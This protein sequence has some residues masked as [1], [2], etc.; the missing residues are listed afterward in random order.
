[1]RYEK[2]FVIDLASHARYV[3]GKPLLCAGGGAAT[4]S[5]TCGVGITA[6]GACSTG[7]AGGLG[8]ACLG[9]TAPG[10]TEDCITGTTARY[11]ASGAA[12]DLDPLGCRSGFVVNCQTGGA[13]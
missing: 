9:G 12:G 6:G 5:E 4:G 7:D 8:T 13:A 10:A 1:M 11:C 3:S 2:P